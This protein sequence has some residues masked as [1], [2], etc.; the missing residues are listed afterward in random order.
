M[1][2]QKEIIIKFDNLKQDHPVIAGKKIPV[3]AVA[4]PN[5]LNSLKIAGKR[6]REAGE[7]FKKRLSSF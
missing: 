2:K 6:G 3:V 7:R 4:F 5:Q 1:R